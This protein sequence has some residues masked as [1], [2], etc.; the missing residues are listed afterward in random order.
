MQTK[1]GLRWLGR[2]WL[3]L[4]C[5]LHHSYNLSLPYY[6]STNLYSTRYTNI[7][8][9]TTR[10]RVGCAYIPFVSDYERRGQKKRP[11]RNPRLSKARGQNYR[12]RI[13]PPRGTC[14]THHPAPIGRADSLLLLPIACIP[15]SL[16]LS[17]SDIVQ[18]G[19][20]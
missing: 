17:L 20:C 4:A 16:S 14:R 3:L 11:G 15:V 10:Y 13:Q 1:W 5:I 12:E 7:H 8:E 2:C 19:Q 18:P 6:T 9:Q